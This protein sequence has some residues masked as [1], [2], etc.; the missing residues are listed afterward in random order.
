MLNSDFV[1]KKI[2]EKDFTFWSGVPCSILG[3][4][5]NYTSESRDLHY[6]SS[7]NEGESVAINSGL[8]LG[9]N[10]GIAVFQNSGLGNAINP[11]TSLVAINEIH[12]P[13]IMS[14]RGNHLGY[15]DEPQHQVMGSLSKKLLEEIGYTCFVL[16]GLPSDIEVFNE[17]LY[18]LEDLSSYPALLVNRK[19]I[20]NVSVTKN[21][22]SID[23][24]SEQSKVRSDSQLFDLDPADVDVTKSEISRSDVITILCNNISQNDI[25][26]STTGY[27]SRELAAI[28]DRDRNFYMVGAM[29][30]ASAVALGI[31][32]A[33]PRNRVFVL[34]GDGAALMR[35][36]TLATI[37]KVGPKNLTHILLNNRKHESTGGQALSSRKDFSFSRVAEIS[38][39]EDVATV[40]NGKQ[41]QSILQSCNLDRLRFIEA[42]INSGTLEYLPRPKLSPKEVTLRFKESL[43]YD[44]GR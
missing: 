34:D 39:Y 11:L 20:K 40:S 32:L 44:D 2:I 38:G 42:Y 14:M 31:A 24:E 13:L 29:G 36:G 27:T 18:N 33:R 8:F 7:S 21:Y 19:S 37:A 22:E 15:V 9:N 5:I 35:L 43:I 16:E 12:A 1:V 3:D 26:V 25:I 28:S 4:F 30:C 41:F 6:I 23:L 10:K 17:F